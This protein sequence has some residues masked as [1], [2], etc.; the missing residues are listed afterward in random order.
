MT[1]TT[2]P[3]LADARAQAFAATQASAEPPAGAPQ[4]PQ[5]LPP[6]AGGIYLFDPATGT[7][8]LVTPSTLQE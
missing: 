6:A 1:T 8:T 2:T 7:V 5:P 3:P 4:P